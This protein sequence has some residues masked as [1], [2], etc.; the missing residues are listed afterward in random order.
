M[1]YGNNGMFGVP[2][3]NNN[4]WIGN[5]YSNGYPQ[6]MMRNNSP[7]PQNNENILQQT[8]TS[9]NNIL[10][11]LGPES[12]QAYQIGPNSKV[13]LLDVAH[14][15]FYIKESDS[16][17]YAK[18]TAHKYTEVPLSQPTFVQPTNEQK[19]ETQEEYLTR[20]EFKMFEK[21][22]E[23]FKQMIEELVMKHE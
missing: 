7:M 23:E 12:A 16:S 20:A 6:Q 21:S 15:M 9:V 8:P 2:Q 19:N 11:V 3:P 13:V 17:G 4:M 14:E 18:L 22:V 5:N 10:Q 1:S